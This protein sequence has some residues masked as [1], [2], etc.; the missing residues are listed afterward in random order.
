MFCFVFLFKGKR[1]VLSRRQIT[2]VMS[3]NPRDKWE[4]VERETGSVIHSSNLLR[5]DGVCKRN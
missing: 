1:T 2:A 4:K 5:N 3:M